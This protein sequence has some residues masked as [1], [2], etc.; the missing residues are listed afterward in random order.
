V[1]PWVQQIIWLL[2]SSTLLGVGW[3]SKSII[4]PWSDAALLRAKAFND[5]VLVLSA[6]VPHIQGK[7]DTLEASSKESNDALTKTNIA[8]GLN[9][10]ATQELS[11]TIKQKMGSDPDDLCRFSTLLK[12]Y[13]EEM[14]DK[15]VLLLFRKMMSPKN[16]QGTQ[17]LDKPKEDHP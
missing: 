9:T 10:N 8:L 7:L 17:Q 13:N 6:S 3:L 5:M 11:Q 14:T 15:E 12:A 1:E 4:K 16:K 2:I